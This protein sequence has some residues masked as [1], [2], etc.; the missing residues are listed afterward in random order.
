MK[1]GSA[2][3]WV[4]RTDDG[5][6]ESRAGALLRQAAATDAPSADRLA[7]I[8][9]RL[10]RARRAPQRH[11]AVRVAI[12]AVLLLS[13]G[14]LT[15]AGQRYFHLFR[16]R[17]PAPEVRAPA[18]SPAPHARVAA[19]G[20]RLTPPP[21]L[22]PRPP[23][24]ETTPRPPPPIAPRPER[25][26]APPRPVAS[27]LAQES[28]LLA[29][30]LQKLRRDADAPGALALLDAHDA[31]FATGPLAPEATR[32]RIEALLKLHRNVEA[33]ALL[34]GAALAPSGGGR[35]LLIARAELRSAAGRCAA[36]VADLDRLLAADRPLDSITERA[37]WGRAA[38][39][40][41]SSDAAGA[42]SDL[43]EY[44]AL[45][46]EGRFAG[47]ARAAVGQ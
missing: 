42:R 3:R 36:A 44:L 38:C 33:L 24:P 13:G 11:W 12:A 34:D 37:F 4:R 46:P 29:R 40:A 27:P 9:R 15:A 35:D 8:R 30:A 10:R 14:A 20:P 18:P 21:E 22:E 7:A 28:E 1:R 31:R 19:R 32:A 25:V 6:P 39:R 16:P 2:D 47:G 5:S 26:A 43:R 17:K 23:E 45:F 41:A